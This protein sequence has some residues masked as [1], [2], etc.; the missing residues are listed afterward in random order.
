[1]RWQTQ[2]R[3]LFVALL[4]VIAATVIVGKQLLVQPIVGMA[5]NG[6]F[7]RLMEFG[8]CTHLNVP[9]GTRYFT[10]IHR[11]FYCEE[12]EARIEYYSS[13]M[14]LIR[15]AVKLAAVI[16]HRTYFDL[17]AL[18]LLQL[19]ILLSAISVTLMALARRP[20]FDS[21]VVGGLFLL[22][23]CDVG[24]VAYFN[25][26]YS[27]PGS[28]LW[29]LVTVALS[30]YLI[31]REPRGTMRWLLL[32]ALFLAM[33]LFVTA[34]AQN[35]VLGGPLALFLWRLG[36]S[37]DEHQQRRWLR[38]S[39]LPVLLLTLCVVYFQGGRKEEVKRVNLYHH[40]F[41]ELLPSSSDPESDLRALE[42]PTPYAQLSGTSW[43]TPGIPKDDPEFVQTFYGKVSNGSILKF[44]L[45]RPAR[46]W[47]L[48]ARNAQ[49][50]FDLRPYLGNFEPS[51]GHPPLSL[52]HRFAKW[53][54][55]KNSL[56]SRPWLLLFVFSF[57]I[58]V[59]LYKY[60]WEDR[61]LP[62]RL[63]TELHALLVLCGAA[64]YATIL[65]GEGRGEV[66]RYM[67]IVNTFHDLALLFLVVYG[68]A[69]VRQLI[70]RL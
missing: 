29:L 14:I 7:E 43:F 50:A 40:V 58:G 24:Y 13:Q 32:F 44:Y 4:V 18:S 31:L 34:K 9:T 63:V 37:R 39:V 35:V 30:L 68:L 69:K 67:L 70:A 57:H 45:L 64:A 36:A 33:V 38:A 25:S 59:I 65:L 8:R 27:E 62:Q 10:H 16:W 42:L 23:F 1:M 11:V 3:W 21:I 52:S 41:G 2:T 47:G 5:D 15:L 55:W 60:R 19:P 46:L 54:A 20:L 22:I 28:F 66:V 48:F 26:F 51:A 49:R 6:D 56:P 17:R 53:S 61:T 12:N